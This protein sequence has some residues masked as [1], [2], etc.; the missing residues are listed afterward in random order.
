MILSGLVEDNPQTD[1]D[2]LRLIAREAEPEIE[3]GTPRPALPAWAVGDAEPP[4]ADQD[5]QIVVRRRLR[6]DA[7]AP[8]PHS[9]SRLPVPAPQPSLDGLLPA[10]REV[11][12]HRVAPRSFNDAQQ[13]ADRFKASIPV[14][15]DMEGVDAD[16]AKRLI[17]FAS[18]LTYGLDG[19]MERLDGRVFL[20][21]PPGVEIPAAQRARLAAQ[22]SLVS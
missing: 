5:E 18:G 3:A 8:P 15:L 12:V 11:S 6:G 2:Y 14:V 22:G 20:L 7:E 13:V 4:T 1:P 10:Q 16:L 21:V 19:A 17:G 9:I